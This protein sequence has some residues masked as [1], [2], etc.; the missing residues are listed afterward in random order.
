MVQK[1]AKYIEVFKVSLLSRLAYVY[2]VLFRQLF[3]VIIMYVFAQLWR[4]TYAWEGT[5]DIS[6]FTMRQMIWYLALA[7]SMVMGMP[8]VGMAIDEEVKSGS[9]AYSL[10]RPYNYALFHYAGYMAEAA[11]RFVLN[12]LIAGS[13]T[14]AI[15]G[16]PGFSVKASLAGLLC[17]AIGFAIDFGVQ[18]GIGLTAFWVEDTWAFRFLYTRIVMIFGGMM[19]PLDI[20][21]DP[22]RRLAQAL[23]T[24]L[25]VYGPVRTFIS[26]SAGEWAMLAVKQVGWLTALCVTVTLVY[27]KGVKRVNVHGG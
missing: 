3:L 23:P 17:V 7:E 2:D 16:P 12:L 4:T 11:F 27:K 21:P 22:V 26:F 20:L 24:S 8:A 13:V 6:G 5:A 9:L 19:L 18:F 15:A 10:G 1:A 25:I 14:W